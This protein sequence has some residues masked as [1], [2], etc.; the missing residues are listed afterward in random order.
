[1]GQAYSIWTP[2]VVGRLKAPHRIKE[3]KTYD[4]EKAYRKV[5]DVKVKVRNCRVQ[6]QGQAIEVQYKLDILCLL[7]DLLGT[8]HLIAKEEMGR[9]RILLSQ[10]DNYIDKDQPIKYVVNTLT[11]FSQCDLNGSI[12]KVAYF[13]DLTIIATNEQIITLSSADEAEPENDSLQEVLNKLRSQIE[14]ME[15]EKAALRRKIFFYERDISS[16][17]K[18]LK[19][20]ENKN[21]HLNKELQHYHEIVE[22]LR[23]AIREKEM[24]LNQYENAYYNQSYAPRFS[25]PKENEDSL[26]LGSRIKRMF[27]NN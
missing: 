4:I 1:M 6:P 24:R 23:S 27:M 13:I 26:T 12:L 8:M 2:V 16:L 18:G 25:L 20:A 19:K 21:A 14:E 22:Q 5:E 7:E 15:E 3:E 17:K 9:E 11:N 10:F